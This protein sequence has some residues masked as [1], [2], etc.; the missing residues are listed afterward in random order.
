MKK[1]AAD[2]SQLD[3]FEAVAARA[4]LDQ[5]LT[6]ARLYTSSSSYRELM[7]FVARFRSFAP[8]NAMLLHIQKPGLTYAASAADWRDRFER[9][10]KQSARP[11]LILWPFGPVALVYDIQDTEGEAVPEDATMFPARG[12]V[13]DEDIAGHIRLLCKHGISTTRIDAG[14]AIA[15]SIRV[16]SRPKDPKKASSYL[17]TINHNHDAPKQFVTIAHELAHLFLGHL[18]AD[19]NLKIPDR[20]GCCSEQRE[21]EAESVAWLVAERNGV[22]AKS[23]TYLRYF[24]EKAPEIDIYTLLR[25]TGRIEEILGLSEYA[26]KKGKA[27]R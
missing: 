14:A 18:G 25:A 8:F 17:L 5:L 23:E 3:M 16:I 26:R 20:L 15:G 7:E 2:S 19:N 4:G 1:R 27:P 24:V 12:T 21:V 9:Y 13:T 6:E 22:K 10:P 11:L